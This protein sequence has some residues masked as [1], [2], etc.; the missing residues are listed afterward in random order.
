MDVLQPGIL[1]KDNISVENA[2]IFYRIIDAQKAIINIENFYYATM[3]LAQTTMRNVVMR[4]TIFSHNVKT[5][6]KNQN[7]SEFTY[8]WGIEVAMSSKIF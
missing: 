4:S 2:V 5:S 1:T 6:L 8:T 7:W 3:Q